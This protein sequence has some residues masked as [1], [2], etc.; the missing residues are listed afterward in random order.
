MTERNQ[1]QQ[2][3]LTPVNKTKPGENDRKFIPFPANALHYIHHDRMSASRLHLYTILID[4]YNVKEGAAWPSHETLSVKSG[5][6]SRSIGGHLRDLVEAGLL[7]IPQKGQYVPLEPLDVDAFYA[8]Y[9]K[10][11]RNYQDALK[12]S[13]ERKE[14]SHERWAEYRDKKRST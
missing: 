8:K 4:H 13:E 10:A 9:P 6:S 14:A 7:A 11:W 1:R 5:I 12:S 3:Q 2:T